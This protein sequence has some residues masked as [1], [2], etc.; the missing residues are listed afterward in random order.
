MLKR[1]PP[2][3]D[4]REMLE[5]YRVEHF[6]LWLMYAL[7][8][9]AIV[10]QL[11]M[12][13]KLAQMAGELAV[14][15]VASAAMMVQHVRYGIWDENSRPSVRGN[16]MCSLGVGVGVAAL[17]AVLRGKIALALIAGLCAAALCFVT[18][19]LLMRYMLHRQEKEARELDNE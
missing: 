8:C 19:T 14:V 13:A 5:M 16:A 1:K 11:L 18:L 9:I 7:L 6:G 3:L 2:V 10:V 4:E 15:I 17:L 12:G